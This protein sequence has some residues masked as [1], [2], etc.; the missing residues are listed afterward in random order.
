MSQQMAGCWA[1]RQPP[2]RTGLR[3]P[4]SE[5]LPCLSGYPL[6][7]A[8]RQGSS[9]HDGPETGV[10]APGAPVNIS[11]DLSPR[12]AC[13]SRC[14][15]LLRALRCEAERRGRSDPWGWVVSGL[16]NG[17]AAT[18]ERFLGSIPTDKGVSVRVLIGEL[19]VPSVALETN[20]WAWVSSK[21]KC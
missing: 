21:V 11:A 18:W 3:A 8:P 10:R 1:G 20:G 4:L 12:Q 19:S 7:T 17:I 16:F 5:S 13:D 6:G 2:L 14:S 9:Q 15:D